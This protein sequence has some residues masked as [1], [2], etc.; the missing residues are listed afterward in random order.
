MIDFPK[1]SRKWKLILSGRNLTALR[2]VGA[3]FL[4]FGAVQSARAVKTETWDHKTSADFESAKLEK[5]L[6][7][8][9]GQIVLAPQI[10]VLLKDRKDVDY[11]NAIVQAA[12]GAIYAGAGPEGIVFRVDG[13]TT[14][15]YFKTPGVNVTSLLVGRGNIL[16]A[17]VGGESGKIYQIA[18]KDKAAVVFERE[19]VHYI[20]AMVEG[21]K[22]EIYAAT[23]PNGELFEIRPASGAT[24]IFKAK[25]EKNL[26]SLAI[27]P[28]GVIY[29]GSDTNGLIYRIDP[30]SE[31]AS[32][33]YDANEAEISALLLDSRGDLFAG[34]A[35]A[36]KSRPQGAAKP[37]PSG[38]RPAPGSPSSRP[39]GSDANPSSP[40][41]EQGAGVANKKG[42]ARPPGR[43]P[44]AAPSGGKKG[45]NAVYR[46]DT[47]GYVTEVF[48]KP[49]MVLSLCWDTQGRLLVGTGGEGRIHRLSLGEEILTKL[50]RLP[51][52][53]I[54]SLLPTADGSIL[55]GTANAG[56]I[57]RIDPAYVT[58]GVVTSKELDASRLSLWGTLMWRGALP[59]AAELAIATR[60]GNG[61]E[62]DDA[63]WSPW[64]TERSP[65]PGEG[66]HIESPA[67]RRFLQYR[68][69]MKSP[70]GKAS[71]EVDRVT[72]SYTAR[73]A[74][75][76]V[77]SI[78]VGAAG[79]PGGPGN[80]GGARPGGRPATKPILP[81][82]PRQDVR[83]VKWKV[84]DPNGDGLDY[85]LFFRMGLDNGDWIPLKDKLKQPR[86]MWDTKTVSDGEYEIKVRA[87]DSR[88][89]PVG[90]G[91]FDER[92][93]DPITVDNT[94][95]SIDRL[96]VNVVED[97]ISVSLEV[98]DDRSRVMHLSYSVDS[99]E[100]YHLVAP[101]DDVFDEPSE[102]FEFSV[103]AN[104]T[105]PHVLT[106][107][108]A[109][110][111]GNIAYS[112]LVFT[113]TAP[114]SR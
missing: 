93:T 100:K 63:T 84:S 44:G 41:Q 35:D 32:V 15:P 75:P 5:A 73:N 29:A 102:T 87:S 76:K 78:T 37:A 98:L 105:G 72:V 71:P 45:G 38:G 65:K 66:F 67:S 62:A 43:R 12:D 21:P 96:A 112:S 46:I 42:P 25:K 113:V 107:R 99:G 51:P 10:N 33:L 4:I 20:W 82:L 111:N 34:T 109:D 31:K 11:V 114:E 70:E 108:A 53:E 103:H 19:G 24:V 92:I 1:T 48:R 68:I 64:S 13:D 90:E 3:L 110:E 80:K 59:K 54:L 23:G 18:E 60:S 8:S 91:M 14:E 50:E 95:P 57:H 6:V 97:S 30:Q 39:T 81:Q 83:M 86:F 2:V 74:P 28:V 85:E 40:E 36:D 69:T 26:L 88:S 104:K 77:S 79:R 9:R 22:G 58:E 27:S 101:S 17:G 47:T 94:S 52:Q 89:N 55:V 16:Y 49:G 56:E 106:L 61:A 7:T